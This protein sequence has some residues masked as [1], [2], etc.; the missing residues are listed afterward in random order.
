MEITGYLLELPETENINGTGKR[1]GHGL[2]LL[3]AERDR[4]CHLPGQMHVGARRPREQASKMVSLHSKPAR[5]REYE[6]SR[7][8]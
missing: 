3:L 2:I 5:S 7:I 6:K 8:I 4:I 1:Q